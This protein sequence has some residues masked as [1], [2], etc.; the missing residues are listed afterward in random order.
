[1]KTVSVALFAL[2]ALGTFAFALKLLLSKTYFPYHEQVT[3]KRW[4]DL[5]G[6]VRTVIR[7][8]MRLFGGGLLAANGRSRAAAADLAAIDESDFSRLGLNGFL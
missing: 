7:G 5:D 1:M 3:G 8:F 2:A 4:E 6:G